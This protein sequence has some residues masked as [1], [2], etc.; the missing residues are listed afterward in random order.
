MFDG[1]DEVVNVLAEHNISGDWQPMNDPGAGSRL[2]SGDSM[3]PVVE[4]EDAQHILVWDSGDLDTSGAF[5]IRITPD[6]DDDE[7]DTRW[8]TDRAVTY[9]VT[10]GSL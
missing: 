2:L 4:D 3:L 7:D 9:P 10:A 8:D 5:D 6:V 1:D